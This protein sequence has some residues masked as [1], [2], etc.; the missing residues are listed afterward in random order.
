M[1]FPRIL[2][3]LYFIHIS[4]QNR[5]ALRFCLQWTGK[6]QIIFSIKDRNVQ[7]LFSICRRGSAYA[8]P[9]SDSTY[10]IMLQ[11]ALVKNVYVA[12]F[13]LEGSFVIRNNNVAADDLLF[14]FV[15]CCDNILRDQI[16]RR[17]IS[18]PPAARSKVFT[19]PSRVPS[20]SS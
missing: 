12:V 11:D 18:T 20:I 8:G 5:N 10:F 14:Y 16:L 1:F 17:A 2:P 4:V 13:L 19:P 9:V 3:P 15:N 6:S 7:T